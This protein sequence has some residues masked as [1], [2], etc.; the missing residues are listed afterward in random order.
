L[1]GTTT[2]T[3]PGNQHAADHA[4]QRADHA[5]Q[6]ALNDKYFMISPGAA[7]SVRRMD[8]VCAL[9]CDGHDQRRNDIERGDRNDQQ[10]DDEHNA[11]FD[12]HGAEEIGGLRV[13]SAT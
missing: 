13:Q 1:P 3:F 7:P 5:D 4:K 9:V 11:L 10:Q 2:S 8:N 12:L 6:S